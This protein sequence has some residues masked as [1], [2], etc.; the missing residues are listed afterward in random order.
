MHPIL[1]AEFSCMI[2]LL[3]GN[4]CMTLI[5]VSVKIL[6]GIS[7]K[8]D[9]FSLQAVA[10]SNAIANPMYFFQSANIS[11]AVSLLPIKH[12]RFL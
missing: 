10:N 12:L 11:H 4:L 5:R 9:L 6:G 2:K 3:Y 1:E 8:P 7:K